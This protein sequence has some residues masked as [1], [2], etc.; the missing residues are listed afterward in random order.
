MSA[1]PAGI[2]RSRRIL[3]IW[4]PALAMDRCRLDNGGKAEAVRDG[5]FVLITDH[6]HG[7]RIEA[8]NRAAAAAGAV[9][10][11]ML[12]DV[13]ALCPAIVTAP[14]DPAGDLFFLEHLAVWVQ[15]WGPWSAL[16]VP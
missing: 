6:A 4:L 10:G 5:P 1:Q 3:S 12:A 2:S 11:T 13:R 15:R 7:P 8:V 9:K 16:D 14:S